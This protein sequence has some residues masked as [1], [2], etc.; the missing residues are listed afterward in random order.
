M[1]TTDLADMGL[2]LL[3]ARSMTAHDFAICRPCAVI[4]RAYSRH[5]TGVSTRYVIATGCALDIAAA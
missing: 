3:C 2:R 5:S 1:A 4:D